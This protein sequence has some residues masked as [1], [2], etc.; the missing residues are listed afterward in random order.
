MTTDAEQIPQ[1]PAEV[2]DPT[3]APPETDSPD[4]VFEERFARIE[5][6]QQVTNSQI[7]QINAAVGRV[8]SLAAKFDKTGDPQVED[9]VRAAMADVYAVL[10]DITDNIDDA[11]LPRSA[12]AK[13]E[14]A[15]E[16]ARR[17]AD[18][19]EMD[20]RVQAAVA[21]IAPQPASTPEIDANAI[22]ARVLAEVARVGADADKLDWDAAATLLHSAGEPAMWK[23]ISG[24]VA[25][26]L[27]EIE[28]SKT[29]R[30]R[31]QS[32]PA[33]GPAKDIGPLDESKSM[34]DRTAW[35]RSVG[36]L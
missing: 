4:K 29:A 12:K 24:Q 30:P 34:A 6:S 2:I 35:L 28:G 31:V 16:A 15:R 14:S 9:K 22:E 7:Q 8:Q 36:A 19:M 25:A 23:F 27:K 26:Q 13:V 10:G 32:P 11:I 1:E 20:T 18:Q 3:V 21:K 17:V 33:A 5:A